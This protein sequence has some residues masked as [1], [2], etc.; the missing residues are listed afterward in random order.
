MVQL[1]TE[2][3]VP[4]ME[5]VNVTNLM[6]E[7]FQNVNVTLV[8]K[9]TNVNVPLTLLHVTMTMELNVVEKANVNVVNVSVIIPMNGL[10]YFVPFQIV[11]IVFVQLVKHFQAGFHPKL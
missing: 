1:G 9:V 10:D 8:S 2:E 6:V 11:Q 3:S 4:V 7:V 5:R